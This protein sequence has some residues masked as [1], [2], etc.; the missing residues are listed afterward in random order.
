MCIR[1]R[2]PIKLFQIAVVDSSSVLLEHN[3]L[4]VAPVKG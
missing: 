2:Q 4:L 1:D 3:R